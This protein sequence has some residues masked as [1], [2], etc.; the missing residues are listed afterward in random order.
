MAIQSHCQRQQEG[1]ILLW[2]ITALTLTVTL[3]IS[4]NVPSNAKVLARMTILT[5]VFWWKKHSSRNVAHYLSK[6]NR[7]EREYIENCENQADNKFLKL[8]QNKAY[9]PTDID[10]FYSIWVNDGEW[11]GPVQVVPPTKGYTILNP[12]TLSVDNANGH[13]TPR[14]LTLTVYTTRYKRQISQLN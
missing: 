6:C 1:L 9:N 11:L 2:A 7:R 8:R 4:Q 3:Y 14:K 13:M 5:P 12:T 10:V